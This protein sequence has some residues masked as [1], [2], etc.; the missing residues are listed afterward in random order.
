MGDRAEATQR[1]S[2]TGGGAGMVRTVVISLVIACL[3]TAGAVAN[4]PPALKGTD[5]SKPVR[6]A[7]ERGNYPWYDAKADAVK[8][9]WPPREW[10]SDWNVDWLQGKT[11]NRLD[12]AGNWIANVLV[13]L[14]LLILLV[15]L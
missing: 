14:G 1:R 10:D 5:P 6:S 4:E 13:M 8:P 9:V 15:V 12:Q 11:A 7:L 2:D 3:A